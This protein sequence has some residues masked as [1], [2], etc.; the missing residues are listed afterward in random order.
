MINT[1]DV[2]KNSNIQFGT[3]GARG[4][5]T[6][7]TIESCAAFTHAF[8]NSMKSEF[9]F[10]KI[11]IAIDNRP[12][13]EFIAT[14]CI[15]AII[16]QNIEPIYYGV[17]PT[18]AL[19]YTAMSNGIPCIM[20]TGSHIPF[21]RNGLKFYRPD[22]EITKSDE[23][24]ILNS[25]IDFEVPNDLSLLSINTIAT[26]TEK[27]IDR[28]VS[29]FD[30]KLLTGKRIG[31]YEHSSAGRD[32]YSILFKKFGAEVISLER[33]NE[34]VPIDTEAVSEE[35]KIKAKNWSELYQLDAIFSTDGD[36]DRPLVADENGEWLR[37]DILGLLC[38]L[39]MDIEALAIPISCNTIISTHEHFKCVKQTKIGSPYVIEEFTNL[40]KQYKRIA[41]F[42]ANGGFLLGSDITINDKYLSSLPT[43][44]AVLPFLMLLSAAK[45][46]S[47]SQLVNELPPRITFSDRIQNFATNR[48]ERI[49]KNGKN[50][51]QH[52]LQKLGFNNISLLDLN[53]IDGLR[54]TLSNGNIIHLRSS[55]NAPEL[56]CYTEAD[57]AET[58]RSLVEQT[59]N[60]IKSLI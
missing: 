13:S 25:T 53:A 56:R 42:E 43:R 4:L 31:I 7:F 60:K 49:I 3:S 23:A 5:V 14:A 29:I 6:Q 38:A 50:D 17:I 18:P 36:G 54:M 51:P 21:D 1:S 9:N 19:A 27:Y 11:A 35:D 22:G 12:S 30:S 41:G 47:I 57:S 48:S 26:A 16:R 45:E 37:G 28:Y 33:S 39:E 32:I 10:D 2:I 20:V 55:G 44:D 24:K 58:A 8:I 52:L 40:A 59:L 34:F 46:K 15:D